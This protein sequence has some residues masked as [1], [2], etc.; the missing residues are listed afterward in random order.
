MNG[1]TWD[2]AKKQAEW[3]IKQLPLPP[4]RLDGLVVQLFDYDNDATFAFERGGSVTLHDHRV[5]LRAMKQLLK[6]RGAEVHTFYTTI[7]SLI[8]WNSLLRD[9]PKPTAVNQ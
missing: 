2:E 5:L 6:A 8:S 3:R 7:D 9:N 4:D 1:I